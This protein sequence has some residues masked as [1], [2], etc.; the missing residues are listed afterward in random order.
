M[1][2]VVSFHALIVSNSQTVSVCISTVL[3]Y[4][5][6]KLCERNCASKMAELSDDSDEKT[7][8]IHCDDNATGKLIALN[9]HNWG[10]TSSY[11][12]EWKNLSGVQANIAK[13]IAAKVT[14]DQ[15]S[16]TLPPVLANLHF[17]G[18]PTIVRH[19][20]I[21][22]QDCPAIVGFSNN[23]ETLFLQLV[24]HTHCFIIA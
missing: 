20:S 21:V 4:N 8:F 24:F 6:P 18:H 15:N 3:A 12:E 22:V 5:T 23:S 10:H 1:N 17:G 2:K 7:Y 9:D 11:T 16:A 13:V 19:L 14:G